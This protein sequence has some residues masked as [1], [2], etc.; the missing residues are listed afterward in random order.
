MAQPAHLVVVPARTPQRWGDF[1]PPPTTEIDI[2]ERTHI[3]R[4]ALPNAG[5]WIFRVLVLAIA[6]GGPLLA[7]RGEHEISLDIE[8]VVKKIQTY[9][10]DATSVLERRGLTI[11][12][13]DLVAPSA[14]SSDA[15]TS[16]MKL[17]AMKLSDGDTVTYRRAKR[18]RL[19]LDG[20]R[21]T[22]TARGL[23]VGEALKDLGMAPG[24]KDHLYPSAGTKLRPGLSIYVRN[25][26]HTKLRVDGRLRDVV[27]SADSVSNLLTQAG[28][29][30]GPN[31]YVIPDRRIEPTDGMWI[32]VVRVRRIEQ[33]KS[34][35]VPFGVVTRHDP[36]L[37][38]GVRRVVQQGAEGLKVQRYSVTLEDGVRVSSR[39]TEET[40]IRSARDHI[41]RV[42][43]KEPE[44]TGG[45]GASQSGLASWFEAE[46]LVAAHRSLPIGSVVKVT[47]SDTGKSVTVRI[48]Q[49]GPWVEGR[50]IDL[51]DD[52]FERLAP[53]GAGTIKVTVH[54]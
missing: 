19:V 20:E 2:P 26:I 32:R 24:P 23:T 13:D 41:I 28:V 45:D 9:A 10:T 35:R 51:S 25:A 33:E 50:I 48:N 27:S 3:S 7:F 42:G 1:V 36:E 18:V 6:I 17:S 34:V 14:T 31:D 4:A 39:M 37:E 46:G 21:Q 5:R 54:S 22:V 49:R 47:D 43:T 16:A 30:V 38:S 15:K 11:G 12:E 44:Y 40:V 53:L 29:S 8:G 52:A